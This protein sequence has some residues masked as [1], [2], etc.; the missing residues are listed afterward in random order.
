M[1]IQAGSSSSPE[2]DRIKGLIEEVAKLNVIH[3]DAVA[4]ATGPCNCD[5]NFYKKAYNQQLTHTH[6][7]QSDAF[8]WSK[9]ALKLQNEAMESKAAS[10][11][12]R[13]EHKTW[14]AQAESRKIWLQTAR[15]LKDRSE[16]RD[17]EVANFMAR[18]YNDDITRDV[19]GHLDKQDR[20]LKDAQAAKEKALEEVASLKKELANL[21]AGPERR[22]E[23]KRNQETLLETAGSRK[24]KSDNIGS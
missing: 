22:V 19:M 10:E 7:A 8:Y 14:E 9:I 15:I 5:I 6:Q 3:H 16:G 12:L 13:R 21:K 1:L 11:E 18:E 2:W 17:A 23:R 20:L 4:Q 24:Q